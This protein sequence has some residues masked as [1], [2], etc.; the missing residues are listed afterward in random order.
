MVSQ[1]VAATKAVGGGFR[2]VKTSRQVK[3]IGINSQ[4]LLKSKV[5]VVTGSGQGIGRAVVKA[6]AAEGALVVVN[7]IVAANAEKV[8]G[9]IGGAGGKAVSDS[10]DISTWKGAE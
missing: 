7:D 4:M 3:P 5:A 8:A 2:R 6:L 9:E 10:N 1:Q